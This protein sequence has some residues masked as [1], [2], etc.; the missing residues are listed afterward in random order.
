MNKFIRKNSKEITIG[1]DY[2]VFE[3]FELVRSYDALPIGDS[4]TRNKINLWAFFRKE[5]AKRVLYR[6]RFFQSIF[7]LLANANP[8]HLIEVRNPTIITS[9]IVCIEQHQNEYRKSNGQT[10]HIN[11]RIDLMSFQ[12]SPADF[13]I[14]FIHTVMI[15]LLKSLC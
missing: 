1:M 7:I 14:T 5:R 12:I 11:G 2:F 9:L 3:K 15:Q 8:I 6:W 4:Y 10:S 13:K